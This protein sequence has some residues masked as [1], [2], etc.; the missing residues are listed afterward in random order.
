MSN[1]IC[2]PAIRSLKALMLAEYT[3]LTQELQFCEQTD[4]QAIGS[5]QQAIHTDN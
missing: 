5:L 1:F 2:L 3:F 4:T